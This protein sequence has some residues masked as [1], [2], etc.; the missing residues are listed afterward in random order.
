MSDTEV[1]PKRMSI[2]ELLIGGSPIITAFVVA[3]VGNLQGCWSD[4]QA[5]VG[6]AAVFFGGTILWA[7]LRT[8][9]VKMDV[10][11]PLLIEVSAE[12]R[13]HC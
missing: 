11:A 5:A 13:T 7:V 12:D 2:A 8:I 6:S 10:L 9:L 1:Q 4:T 3:I